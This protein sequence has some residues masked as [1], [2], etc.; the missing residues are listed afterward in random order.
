MHYFDASY[1]IPLVRVEPLSNRVESFIESLS[2]T[3]FV[4]SLWTL[5]EC[6]SALAREVRMGKMS[7]DLF[8]RCRRELDEFLSASVRLVLPGEEDYRL[9]VHMIEDHQSGLRAGDAMH[10]AMARRLG[11]AYLLTLDRKL[12]AT[13]QAKGIA[14]GTG[15]D[16][17]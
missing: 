12:A 5:V 4:T 14:A 15:F 10:L 7:T 17:I 3:G 8:A 11:S 9:A 1:L 2:P 6:R 16:D 13:A